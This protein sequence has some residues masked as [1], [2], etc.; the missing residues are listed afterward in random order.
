MSL[1]YKVSLTFGDEASD[2]RVSA[3]SRSVWNAELEARTAACN[4]SSG[5]F[6]LGVETV[7]GGTRGQILHF[8]GSAL[9]FGEES[10]G[11]WVG[12]VGESFQLLRPFRRRRLLRNRLLHHRFRPRM[13]RTVLCTLHPRLSPPL[14]LHPQ[15]P[16]CRS[17]L[18]SL[19][20]SSSAHYFRS[21]I[22]VFNQHIRE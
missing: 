11:C 16:L 7:V 21:A 18:A 1:A 13:T 22:C 20:S 14:P 6:G 3:W 17:C 4:D 8:Q 5:R 12:E 9:G 2:W 10:G 19:R 15:V